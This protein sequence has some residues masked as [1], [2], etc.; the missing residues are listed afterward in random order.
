MFEK[1]VQKNIE[2][3]APQNKCELT[4]SELLS[5][6]REKH[7]RFFSQTLKELLKQI[8][9]N[10]KSKMI[11]TATD[12]HDRLLVLG[13][14]PT[15]ASVPPRVDALAGMKKHLIP[16]HT[17][18]HEESYNPSSAKSPTWCAA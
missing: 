4:P 3:Q 11:S 17:H 10:C 12:M 9:L 7:F 2:A 15:S 14:F 6:Q 18:R 5:A 16:L 13:A 1:S 8:Q